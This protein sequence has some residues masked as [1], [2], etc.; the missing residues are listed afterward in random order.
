MNFYWKCFLL[1]ILGVEG[2]DVKVY[3]LLDKATVDVNIKLKNYPKI[4][5]AI[6]QTLGSTFIGLGDYEK[7][8]T[9]LTESLEA[10]KKLFGLNSKEVCKRFSSTWFVLRLDWQI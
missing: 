5:S 8:K 1:Q 7:A 3:D 4:K 6:K 10:N 9:L 2:K